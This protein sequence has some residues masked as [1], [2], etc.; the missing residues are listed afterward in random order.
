MNKTRRSPKEYL[1]PLAIGVAIYALAS[2]CGGQKNYPTAPSVANGANL[3]PANVGG[4]PNS[5]CTGGTLIMPPPAGCPNP[6]VGGGGIKGTLAQGAIAAGATVG[7]SGNAS[8]L[9]TGSGNSGQFANMSA[10]TAGGTMI[11][12][13]PVNPAAAGAA[14]ANPLQSASGGGGGAGSGAGNGGAAN[15]G[16]LGTGKTAAAEMPAAP[17]DPNPDVAGSTFGGGGGAGGGGKA[18]GDS[19]A[20]PFA[21]LFGGAGGAGG[22]AG[23]A[24][25]RELGF[26]N[27]A[28]ASTMGTADPA[29][30]FS[31]IDLNDN[32]FKRVESRYRD[33]QMAWAMSQAQGQAQGIMRV[34][35]PLQTQTR[36]PQVPK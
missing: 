17:Q 1:I 11:T 12:T 27:R 14:T 18:G 28:P 2:G 8:G 31:R 20:N 26:G 5:C 29:D 24:G 35:A 23:A 10:A 19:G 30:Y 6:V 16:S 21:S 34:T 33:K 3:C 4:T 7:N 15:F 13:A 22:G 25:A 9:A 32:L 36:R